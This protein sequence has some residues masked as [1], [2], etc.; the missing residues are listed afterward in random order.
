MRNANSNGMYFLIFGTIFLVTR[1]VSA[2]YYSDY[3][4]GLDRTGSAPVHGHRVDNV[5]RSLYFL[6]HSIFPDTTLRF[7]AYKHR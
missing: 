4:L 2:I 3:L 1:I 7:S 6:L 5:L